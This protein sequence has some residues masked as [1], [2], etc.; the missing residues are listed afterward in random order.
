M[1]ILN[2]GR[3][4]AAIACLGMVAQPSLAVTPIA[5]APTV[6]DVALADGGLFAGK[7]VNA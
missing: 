3:V 2:A 4:A 6:A 5:T 1:K 7:V